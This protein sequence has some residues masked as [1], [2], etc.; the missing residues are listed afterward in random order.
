MWLLPRVR[1]PRGSSSCAAHLNL[2]LRVH[3]VLFHGHHVVTALGERGRPRL[4]VAREAASGLAPRVLDHPLHSDA[5]PQPQPLHL[6]LERRERVVGR[7]AG[8]AL[9][10][11]DVSYAVDAAKEGRTTG[12]RIG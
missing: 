8:I 6:R 4:P 3:E 11:D 5:G 12:E 10:H 9:V 1:P 2:V 7:M